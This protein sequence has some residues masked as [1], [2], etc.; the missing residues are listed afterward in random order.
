[1]KKTALGFALIPLMAGCAG[2]SMP[3]MPNLWPFGAEKAQERP[4]TPANSTAYLCDKGKRL[5]VRLLDGGAAAWVILPEREFRLDKVPGGDGTRYGGGK[6]VLEL[7]ADGATLTDGPTLSY[8]G[9]KLPK[10][11]AG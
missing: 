9:C 11:A 6:A 10:P 7:Q 8:T 5:Y 2:V 3:S 1:M 4:R